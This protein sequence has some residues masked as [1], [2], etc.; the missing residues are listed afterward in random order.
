MCPQVFQPVEETILQAR[1]P[2]CRIF[3]IVKA[4]LI[5]WQR[6]RRALE[7]VVEHA[8]HGVLGECAVLVRFGC[9]RIEARD[10]LIVERIEDHDVE[11]L[12]LEVLAQFVHEQHVDHCDLG[13]AQQLA[14][15]TT[16]SHVLR[17]LC[18]QE[19]SSDAH[20]FGRAGGAGGRCVCLHRGRQQGRVHAPV[21]EH[22][23]GAEYEVQL[24]GQRVA[25]GT[26]GLLLE[27]FLRQQLASV[28]RHASAQIRR[29]S[30]LIILQP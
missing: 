23:A 2:G 10:H 6:T 11:A 18:S 25:Q 29:K 24:R 7:Y 16:C 5:E 22:V 12:P 20:R 13:D 21:A 9:N 14:A 19:R 4:K 30:A 15:S 26:L 27:R 1:R 17:E 3:F 8:A 28:V